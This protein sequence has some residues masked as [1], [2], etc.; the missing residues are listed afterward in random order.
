MSFSPNR[1]GGLLGPLNGLSILLAIL[2]TVFLTPRLWP[3]VAGTIW[4]ELHALYTPSTAG[5]LFWGAKLAAWPLTYFAARMLIV[6]GFMA[7]SLALARRR[8]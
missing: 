8:M 2:A 5:Y 7:L 1:P 4:Q 6:A 3:L